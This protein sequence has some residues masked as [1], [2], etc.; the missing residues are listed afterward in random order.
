[1]P[2]CGGGRGLQKKTNMQVSIFNKPQKQIRP[3]VLMFF[4]GMSVCFFCKAGHILLELSVSIWLIFP[5]LPNE[6]EDPGRSL[7]LGDGQDR[8]THA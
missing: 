1:M 7:A 6:E 8:S 2:T 3:I 4:V 5:L